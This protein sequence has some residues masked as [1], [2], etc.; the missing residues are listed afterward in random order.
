MLEWEA[1]YLDSLVAF[2]YFISPFDTIIIG[3]DVFDVD[4]RKNCECITNTERYFVLV[5][6][7]SFSEMTTL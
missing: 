2:Y 4:L 5:A 6:N 7:D 1:K 3:K